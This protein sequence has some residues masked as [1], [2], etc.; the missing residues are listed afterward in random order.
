MSFN[1]YR[2]KGAYHYDWYETEPWYRACVDRI[3][4]F[5]KGST[6]DVGCGDGVVVSK[7]AAT[8]VDAYGVDNDIDG[9][10]LAKQRGLNAF[11]ADANQLP[12]IE[13]DYMS[14][15]NVIEHLEHPEVLNK[16]IKENVR[17]GAIII[18]IDWAGGP[19]GE[20][21]KHEYTLPELAEFFKEFHPRPF[22]IK[23]YPD[24][25]GVEILK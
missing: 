8:G 14:C 3:V 2:L 19:L 9:I 13:V 7:L 25:I 23:D 10:A 22:R 6:I 12:E 15:L 4:D 16:I 11:L 5:C 21:H 20:D 1:K 24:W 18:T 17:K